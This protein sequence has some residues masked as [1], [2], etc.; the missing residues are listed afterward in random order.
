MLD[1]K[2]RQFNGPYADVAFQHGTVLREVE[3][4]RNH[5]A[6]VVAREVHE[7]GRGDVGDRAVSLQVGQRL[8]PKC[9]PP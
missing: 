7:K 2:V 9:K 1:S 6:A 4:R 5:A 8:G 3:A